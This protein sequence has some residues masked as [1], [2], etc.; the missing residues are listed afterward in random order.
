[1]DSSSSSG[2]LF[3]EQALREAL[4]GDEVLVVQDLQPSCDGPL[5]RGYP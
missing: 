5:V 1:M 4:G 2:G 3:V